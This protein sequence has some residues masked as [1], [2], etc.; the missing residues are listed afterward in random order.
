MTYGYPYCIDANTSQPDKIIAGDKA[1]PVIFERLF[2]KSTPFDAI[3]GF[4]YCG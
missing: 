4:V 2:G 3:A 1:I